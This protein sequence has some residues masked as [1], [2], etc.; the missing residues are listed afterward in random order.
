MTLPVCRDPLLSFGLPLP[1]PPASSRFPKCSQSPSR[2][3]SAPR[4]PKG[5]Q[6]LQCMPSYQSAQRPPVLPSLLKTLQLPIL[7]PTVSHTAS[8]LPYWPAVPLN[9]QLSPQAPLKALS[10]HSAPAMLPILLKTFQIPHRALYSVP[11]FFPDPIVPPNL[12]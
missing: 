12:P 7:L 11:Q 9:L 1:S 2:S 6:S 8:Q 5:L 3:R 10:P 4:P